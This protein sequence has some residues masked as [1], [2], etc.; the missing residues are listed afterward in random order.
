MWYGVQCSSNSNV[1]TDRRCPPKGQFL[2]E[3]MS[4]RITRDVLPASGCFPITIP[5]GE[6]IFHREAPMSLDNKTLDTKSVKLPQES[7]AGK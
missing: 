1:V 4:S 2:Q 5:V 3:G 7:C 6:R